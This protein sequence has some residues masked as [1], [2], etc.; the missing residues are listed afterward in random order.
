VAVTYPS[1]SG[2]YPAASGLY[3][4]APTITAVG[5][6]RVNLSPNPALKTTTAGNATAWTSSPAGYARQTSV[7]GMD[8]TTG[9]GG[10]GAITTVTSPR[11]A[12]TAGQQ[13]VAS[14][15]V[16]TGGSNTFKVMINWYDGSPS[17]G[18]FLSSTAT[19]SFTVN[20][21]QRCEIGPFTAPLGAGAGYLRVIDIDNTTVTLTAVLV[22]QTSLSGRSYFDGDT[23]GASWQG[24]N[25]NSPSA[26]LVG[27]D[28]WTVTDAGSR[29]A[30][31]SGPAAGDAASFTESASIVA[32][33]TVDEAITWSDAA[34]IVSCDY[35][36]R[37]GRNRISARGL[38]LTGIRAVVESRKEN[39]SAW[40]QVR[41]GK[42]GLSGG[43]F[44]RTVDDYEFAAGQANTYR[45]RVLSTPENVP[46]VV[47]STATVTLPAIS[48]GVWLKFIVQ[49][50]LNQQV[51][52][53]DWSEIARPTRVT[54][55]DV[56]GRTDP[57][58]VTDVHG[59][60]RVT[61]TLRTTGNDEAERLDDALSQ[62][63][64]LFLH[65][66]ATLALPSLYAVAGDY[67]ASRPSKT[68]S[69]RYWQVALIEVSPPPSSAVPPPTTW[70]N[71]LD[72]Y[73][74]WQDV[75]DAF[76]TWQ[77]VVS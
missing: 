22:E 38:P 64:P 35:D 48:P 11:F 76:P 66:P 53:I 6:A 20:G 34:M 1:A 13:Y 14:V 39:R 10:T 56:V 60:R 3:P 68:T 54:L 69:V 30:T 44:V 74:S 26:I 57:V 55:Y 12:A 50:A 65:V 40:R 51:Q 2:V 73:A 28:S 58:A 32:S 59:S 27:A 31:A 67:S 23:T 24:T 21:V 7:T 43:A 72:S 25:G 19:T 61:V 9:F 29:V 41:G 18:S 46:D 45:I 42:V 75:I 62:G 15:Q 8:R 5:G 4:D 17:S 63:R 52:L 71:V 49:P 70:Q 47:I 33:S 77:D 16:K 36:P 37:R